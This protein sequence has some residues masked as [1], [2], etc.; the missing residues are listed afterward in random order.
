MMNNQQKSYD[1]TFIENNDGKMVMSEN[2]P[3]FSKKKENMAPMFSANSCCTNTATSENNTPHYKI[4]SP[5]TIDTTSNSILEEIQGC[6]AGLEWPDTPRHAQPSTK[7]WAVK[8]RRVLQEIDI[9]TL[10]P[11][12][13]YRCNSSARF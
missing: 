5:P 9:N 2:T 7:F 3:E 10:P 11:S 12:R 1:L 4:Y 8:P 13:H 6:E